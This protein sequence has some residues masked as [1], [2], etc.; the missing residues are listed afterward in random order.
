MLVQN[1]RDAKG[2]GED[3]ELRAAIER[4]I[5]SS[6]SLRNKK[7]LI[8]QVVDFVSNQFVAKD[9]RAFIA[10]RREQV[11]QRIIA[12]GGF[13]FKPAETHVRRPRLP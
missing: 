4:A 5:D 1:H 7:D 13:G 6:P 11:R 3:E 9:W 12:D 2:D 8:E 10:E